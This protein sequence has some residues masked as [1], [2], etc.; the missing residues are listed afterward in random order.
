MIAPSPVSQ[1]SPPPSQIDVRCSARIPRATPEEGRCQLFAG[2]DG[3]H[4]VLFVHDGARM[5]RTWADA[6]HP[7]DVDVA[8]GGPLRP[9]MRG[10]PTPAWFEPDPASTG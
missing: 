9:W 2:H 7:S 4:A 6:D 8:H 3:P 5:V 1:E 10:F